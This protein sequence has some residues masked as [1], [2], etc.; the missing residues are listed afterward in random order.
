M[1][2]RAVVRTADGGVWELAPGEMIGRSHA[3]ALQ[4]DDAGVSEA[5]ALVSLRGRE[6]R[7]FGL[8]GG[9]SVGGPPL[10]ELVLSPGQRIWLT[11]SVAVD[12]V[13]VTLPDAVMGLRWG[14]LPVRPLAGVTSLLLDPPR[15]VA[16]FEQE[17]AAR[18][19]TLSGGWR[20]QIGSAEPVDVEVGARFEVGGVE[21][22]LE[23]ISLQRLST[24]ATVA[25]AEP[26]GRLV[27]RSSFDGAHLHRDGR[28]PVALSGI[29]AR[30]VYELLTCG[31]S[32]PWDVIAAEIWGARVA[33]EPLRR[34][35]DVHLARL[36]GR[37]RDAGIRSDL[38]MARGTG[39]VE[40]VKYPGDTFEVV[41]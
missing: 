25:A 36:R 39:V 10:D 38:L 40:L 18:L 30:I 29:L 14:E 19:W 27:V 2:A 5:H 35:W 23:L 22:A 6:L 8:R 17:A 34:R 4:I 9:F 3:A 32:A 1:Q 28:E 37:L 15:V 33:R 31:G 13:A 24:E 11:P 21:A 41:T 26:S 12:V 16:R 20:L 7:L